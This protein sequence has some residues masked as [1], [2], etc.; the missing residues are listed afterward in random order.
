MLSRERILTALLRHEEG[1]RQKQ[2]TEIMRVNAS[3]MSEFI[4]RLE[5]GGYILRSVDPS[6]KRATLITLT[7][8]G[9][10]RA[11]E[12]QDERHEKMNYIFRNLTEEEKTELLRLL[13][14]I[15][16]SEPLETGITE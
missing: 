5:D 2:L 3:S 8:I 12:L 9:R 1:L 14:K 4:T 11:C 15:L 13:R 7:E 16:E 6:D 10:A